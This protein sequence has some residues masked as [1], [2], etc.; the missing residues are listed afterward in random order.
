MEEN[1]RIVRRYFEEV[2]NGCKLDVAA[3]V[4]TQEMVAHME[5]RLKMRQNAVPD[6]CVTIERQVAEGD[7]VVTIG[8]TRGTHTGEWFTPIGTL[9]PTEKR[10]AFTFTSTMR[11]EGGR[12]AQI[13]WS[14]WDWLELLQQLEVVPRTVVSED[15]EAQG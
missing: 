9:A 10:F 3:E 1:K 13:V 7:I 15:E 5:P 6:W 12:I 11:L 2:V 4:M 8:T 14:N